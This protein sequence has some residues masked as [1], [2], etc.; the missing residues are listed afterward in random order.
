MHGNIHKYNIA[1]IVALNFRM[2]RPV[3]KAYA[4]QNAKEKVSKEIKSNRINN[5]VIQVCQ[6]NICN[7]ESF[8]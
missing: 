3:R 2:P 7:N 8:Y 5:N 1:S 4:I 6:T